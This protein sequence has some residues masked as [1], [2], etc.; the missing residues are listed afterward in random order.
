MY[1]LINIIIIL[2][3]LKRVVAV[4]KRLS[5]S[6]LAFRGATLKIGFNNN[7]NFLWPLSCWL[8]LILSYQT[9]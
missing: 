5:S 7:A 3:V 1:V 9:I 4:I 6:G 2:N 8:N